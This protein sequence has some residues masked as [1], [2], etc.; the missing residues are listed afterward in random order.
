MGYR[1][2]GDGSWQNTKIWDDG[3][4]VEEWDTCTIE[5]DRNK[6][7][8]TVNETGEVKSKGAG[9]WKPVDRIILSGIYMVVSDGDFTN[10]KVIVNDSPLRGIQSLI[11]T[12]AQLE[13]PAIRIA[14][15]MMPNIV[16]NS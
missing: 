16:E 5:V 6:C 14:A 15:V 8:A 13:Y 3:V 10:T 12:I 11:M 2:E 7:V 4:L 9:E 1:I